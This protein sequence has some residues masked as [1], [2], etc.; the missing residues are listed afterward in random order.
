[1]L[2]VTKVSPSPRAADYLTRQMGCSDHVDREQIELENAAQRGDMTAYYAAA[3]R[4][5]EA[6]GRW[7]G[8]GAAL[9]GFTAGQHVDPDDIQTVFA[10]L[11]N[12]LTGEQ[13]GRR[14]QD[15]RTRMERHAAWCEAHPEATDEDRLQAWNEVIDKGTSATAF[16]DF[17]YSA[18]KSVSVVEAALRETGNT[19]WADAIAQAHRTAVDA[20]ARF[21][22][23][24]TWVRPGTH[25]RV[26]D[27]GTVGTFEV[28]DAAV[29]VDF[30]H[31]TSRSSD[32]HLHTH[33]AVLNR[34]TRAGTGQW[35]SVHGKA[36]E[37]LKLKAA[38][39]YED[40]LAQQIEEHTPFRTVLSESGHS[41]EIGGVSP[42]VIAASSQRTRAI[43]DAQA[44]V[45]K[46]FRED[47]GREPSD[48]ERKRLHAK[49]WRD[50]RQAK[51]HASP[52]EQI[53]EWGAKHDLTSVVSA[54]VQFGRDSDMYGR[55][56]AGAVPDQNDRDAMIRAG[57]ARAQSESAVFDVGLLNLSLGKVVS[58]D[59]PNR[60]ELIESLER[61]A[62]TDTSYGLM[63]ISRPE[64]LPVPGWWTDHDEWAVFR[65]PSTTRKLSTRDQLTTEKDVLTTAKQRREPAL[66]GQQLRE[67]AAELRG[68]GL[69]EMQVNA[70]I[71]VM[72]SDRIADVFSAAAGTGK[73]KVVG[74]L[75][76]VWPART[77]GSVIGLATSQN[78]AQ[79]LAEE[80]LSSLN[81]ARF[82]AA[83]EPDPD[84]GVPKH[85]LGANDLLV[86]D[87]S[88]MTSTNEIARI[89][90][91]A[92]AAGAK[93][94][95]TGDPQ[96][97]QAV[98]AGGMMRDLA[99]RNGAFELEN[100][101]RFH[102]EWEKDASLRLRAGD[103]DVVDVYDEHGR[104]HTGTAEEMRQRAVAGYLHD[105]AVNGKASVLVTDS[106]AQAS[107]VSG[108]VQAE[109]VAM[110]RLDGTVLGTL[111]DGNHIMAGDLVQAR[112]N[113]WNARTEGD[114]KA[115]VNRE[116]Y[117]VIG[118]NDTGTHLQVQLEGDREGRAWL[119]ADYVAHQVELGYAGTQHAVEGMTTDTCHA[120]TAG[121]VALTRGR[122]NNVAYLET[123]DGGDAHQVPVSTTA[124]EV[125][126]S[127]LAAAD[128]TTTAL[129]A[130][131]QGIEE[132]QHMTTLVRTWD[133][134]GKELD[135]Y[136]HGDV[137]L[138]VLGTDAAE[139][140]SVENGRDGLFET[141]RRAELHGHDAEQLLRTVVEE[142]PLDR[143]DDLAAV[144]RWRIDKHVGNDTDGHSWA[145]RTGHVPGEL[146]EFRSNLGQMI[147]DR[148][149][150]IGRRAAELGTPWAVNML[151]EVPEDELQRAEWERRAGQI[152]AWRE[153]Q[154][155][156][157]DVAE[158]KLGQQPVDYLDRMM[159]LRA[160]RA[161]GVSP[162]ELDL[163]T[164]SEGELREWVTTAERYAA[165]APDHVAQDLGTARRLAERA[166][167]AAAL[168]SE[169]AEAGD[170]VE[171]ES[172]L[173][174][175]RENEALAARMR[176]RESELDRLQRVR[177]RWIDRTAEIR[178]RAAQARDE[179]QRR[180]AELVSKVGRRVAEQTELFTG[181]LGLKQQ[182]DPIKADEE[183]QAVSDRA[184]EQSWQDLQVHLH[185]ED[186]AERRREEQQRLDR[187]DARAASLRPA[188]DPTRAEQ[189]DHQPVT[190]ELEHDLSAPEVEIDENQG[191]LFEIDELIEDNAHA[192]AEVEQV[193]TTE[194]Q[195]DAHPIEPL[196]SSE[197]VREAKVRA[198]YAMWRLSQRE[199]QAS[200][201]IELLDEQTHEAQREQ[202]VE[203]ERQPQLEL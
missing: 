32:P 121:Y 116:R 173:E 76:Q 191:A 133:H 23:S 118:W 100:V 115:V 131:E 152:G 18:P 80:G 148:E 19:G 149:A 166:E 134:T 129:K 89:Q 183:L 142:R 130:Y 30:D 67:L 202:H 168:A 52:G 139:R 161:A 93:V 158:S 180:G 132:S 189:V 113:D 172:E 165:W 54:A 35:L 136:R 190:D 2:R 31:S 96:Q 193:R 153:M 70:V 21:V 22:E 66:R 8:R 138:D 102:Q 60:E 177:E 105:T 140:I 141:L 71:G 26:A 29:M 195:L 47:H 51:S 48:K 15:A 200:P 42:E 9:L 40:V 74:N 187:E 160:K 182:R 192:L 14:P 109:L 91:V 110:G 146:G 77:G 106:N 55:A 75:S 25:G 144:L 68:Q 156:S 201:E 197:S 69:D 137:L 86:L 92:H 98:G 53:S 111:R 135:D 159:W 117:T 17:T 176:E 154:M 45:E 85:R 28:A 49:A 124:R 164:A 184:A 203:Q 72:S 57:I 34:A 84:T 178:E 169:R 79:V 78:A 171:R 10:K 175:Q 83:Y 59:T 162:E 150:E 87:E 157:D 196:S 120:L 43:E 4:D 5:G 20:S 122:E 50:T 62:L 179:L 112:Q 27:G 147:D 16:Y 181:R 128:R 7:N 101:Y 167:A 11:Q 108:Q 1:M 37:G 82:L 36:W 63:N 41:R 73:S 81:V 185:G 186:E 103:L 39:I 151:G 123:F 126:R 155:V 24:E 94:L 12:P 119:P 95:Y 33:K 145:A 6:P 64:P 88:N 198:E 143:V 97:L 90:R 188:F 174:L 44:D 194:D 65:D 125:M 3:Q 61:E 107:D 99:E 127:Q 56:D 46:R 38:R 104:I 13:L 170:E 114:C 199:E 163:Q 58:M